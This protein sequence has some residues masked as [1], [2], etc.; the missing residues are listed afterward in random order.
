MNRGLSSLAKVLLAAVTI[1]LCPIAGADDSVAV[2]TSPDV[3]GYQLD[4]PTLQAI[5][6]M[7]LRK[8]PDG[9]AIHVFVLPSSNP[10]H[11]RFA[12]EKLGTYSYILQRTWDQ[13]LFT[14]AGLAPEVVGSEAEMRDKVSRSKGAIGYVS[15][16]AS[17]Q[18]GSA[19]A[20]GGASSGERY[21]ARD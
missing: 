14:G 6:L 16:G 2:I 4:R 9:T 12:R 7:R 20:V 3:A 5:Y 19:S 18:A 1:G 8:W 11:G 15:A 17:G 21:V 13:Q 10:L